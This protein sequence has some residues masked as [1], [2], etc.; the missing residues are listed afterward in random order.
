MMK[1]NYPVLK[2]GCAACA[3]RVAKALREVEGVAGADV[4]FAT[5]TATME[6]DPAK[7][8]PEALKAAVVA[9]GYDLV[10]EKDEEQAA[11]EAEEARL[12]ELASLK[13]NALWAM[14]VAVPLLV[15]GMFFMHAPGVHYA[16][17]LLATPLLFWWGRGFFVRAWRGLLHKSA[18]M[19]TLVAVSTGTAYVYSLIALFFPQLWTSRG[20]EPHVYF[21]ASG[22]IIAF[23][24]LGRLLEARAKAKT[25]AAIGQLMNLRPES[26]TLIGRDGSERTVPVAVVGK[27]D[28]LLVKPGG[29]IA[30]D[31]VVAS[32]Q[33]FVDESMLSGEPVAVEKK[34]GDKVFAGTINQ[35]GSFTY[36]AERVGRNT[37]LAK[38]IALVRQAQGSKVP[39]QQLADKVAAVFVPAVMGIALVTLL[40]WTF[41]VPGGTFPQGL[42]S[43]V[44]VLVIAC[45][46]ALGLATPTAIMV[47]I[48]KAA[49]RGILIKDASA[50]EIAGKVTDAVL[51]KTGTLTEGRPSVSDVA[52]S[53]GTGAESRRRLTEILIEMERRSEHPLAEAVTALADNP[54]AALG[55]DSKDIKQELNDTELENFEALPGRGLSAEIGGERYFAGNGAL[56]SDN[57]ITIDSVL[58]TAADRLTDEAKTLVWLA[59]GGEARCVVG[60]SDRLRPTSR[61]A[62][63]KLEAM[64]VTVHLL[65]GDNASTAHAVARLTGISHM[66][67]GVMPEDKADYVKHLRTLGHKV[68][69]AGDGINDSAALAEADLGVA[70]GSGSD[71][72]ISVAGITLV[73]SDPL[74]I[75]EAIGI[76]RRTIRI[77]RQ[78]LFWAFFYNVIGIPVAAGVLIPVC[79]FAL[80][81]MLA[82][83]AMALSSVSVVTNSL[84]LYK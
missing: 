84:R 24:L 41:L 19:D 32:G 75:A 22:V 60:I 80:N 82:G 23:V 65:T 78:N 31:G 55:S 30:V 15:L 70:M 27:G 64:G 39:V 18:N 4:N 81:P 13:K 34:Q 12:K 74:K 5:A 8:S 67:S 36:R 40:A 14:V 26:V 9:A 77:I 83:A 61:E 58:K 53:E 7:T 6:F 48:G 49:R 51:D 73:G 2:L 35:K 1:T 45:P 3:A 33:S 20:M 66:K 28:T 59:E 25:S 68:A 71:I 63:G 21:E 29:R 47:G 37:T 10:I 43:A 79:G 11:K 38:I 54:K 57:G 16:L 72:A 52:W 50:L 62:V 17:W 42:V 46:C 56:L 44:T 69:M 76:S